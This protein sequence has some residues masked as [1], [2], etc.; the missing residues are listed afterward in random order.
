ME[1]LLQFATDG[2]TLRVEVEMPITAVHKDLG[3]G[4]LGSRQHKLPPMVKA[5]KAPVYYSTHFG[6]FKLEF[7][8]GLCF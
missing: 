2:R 5:P 3:E 8:L 1:T 7:P 4:V 6:P